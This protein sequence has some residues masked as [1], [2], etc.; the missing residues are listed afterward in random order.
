MA[1]V[2]RINDR[3]LDD[4]RTRDTARDAVSSDNRLRAQNSAEAKESSTVTKLAA[5]AAQLVGQGARRGYGNG[6]PVGS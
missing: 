6:S 2:S 1:D 5:Q 3:M 4:I